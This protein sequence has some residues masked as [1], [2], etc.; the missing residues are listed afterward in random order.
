MF[1]L[2]KRRLCIVSAVKFA[3]V[4]SFKTIY[5]RRP[6]QKW[7]LGFKQESDVRHGAPDGCLQRYWRNCVLPPWTDEYDD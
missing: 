4:T 7:G 2:E 1:E 3:V 5:S 6:F